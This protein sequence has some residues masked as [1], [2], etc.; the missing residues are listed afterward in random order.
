MVKVAVN[1][2][3]PTTL[4]AVKFFGGWSFGSQ[5]DM[6][7]LQNICDNQAEIDSDY[8][9]RLHTKVNPNNFIIAMEMCNGGNLQ[10]YIRDRGGFLCEGEARFFLQQTIMGLA[11]M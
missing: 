2:N 5:D 11:A 1:V 9:V 3:D 10:D 8:V 7:L 4:F 6:T